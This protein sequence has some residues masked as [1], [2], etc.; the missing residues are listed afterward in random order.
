MK[1]LKW[2]WYGLLVIGGYLVWNRPNLPIM[3]AAPNIM[4]APSEDIHA[5]PNIFLRAPAPK[6]RDQRCW[7]S[8]EALTTGNPDCEYQAR[9]HR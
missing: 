8:Y 5:P 4:A 7:Q 6:Y 1:H 9:F 3:A 2:V